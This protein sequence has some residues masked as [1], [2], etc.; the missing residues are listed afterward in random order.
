ME[1]IMHRYIALA[2]LAAAATT[3]AHAGELAPYGGESIALGSMRG[4]TYYTTSA[5][6]YRVVTTLADGETGLPVRF[7]TTLADKQKVKVSVPGKFGEKTIAL[8]IARTGDK[9]F[10]SRPQM[11]DGN[12]VVSQPQAPTD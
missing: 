7:E 9:V 10:L 1:D 4:V 12:L 8:E 5:S 11:V 6:G 2:A 3:S